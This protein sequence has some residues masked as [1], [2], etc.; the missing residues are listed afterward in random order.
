MTTLSATIPPAILQDAA[1]QRLDL[2]A[3][4][5]ALQPASGGHP[6]AA[7]ALQRPAILRRIAN[8]LAPHIP[9]GTDRLVA[10]AG[11]DT[12]LAAALS[13]HSGIAFALVELPSGL[14]HGELHRSERTVLVS[15]EA[16]ESEKGVLSLLEDAGAR[17]A[18]GL[19]VVGPAA[20]NAHTSSLTRH[21]L[22]GSAEL[23]TDMKENH[24]D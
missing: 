9:A 18:L 21:T 23:S 2:A 22:F 19:H 3:D 15:Y 11:D 13:L 24:H 4:L 14:V 7:M 16:D 5:K 10:R 17:P 12:I 1:E 6:D 20:G 8:A